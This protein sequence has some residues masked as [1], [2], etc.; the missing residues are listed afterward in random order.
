MPR[1]TPPPGNHQLRARLCLDVLDILHLGVFRVR[2]EAVL[3]AVRAAEDVVSCTLN[4][5]DSGKTKVP[6]VNRVAGEIPGLQTVREWQPAQVAECQ[7]E[8]ESIG[9]DVHRCQNGR[10]VV[11]RVKDVPEL[12]DVDKDHR[13]GHVPMGVVLVGEEGK[14]EDRPHDHSGAELAEGLEVEVVD[15]RVEGPSDEPVVED[16]AGVCGEQLAGEEGGGVAVD[17]HGDR[18][19]ERAGDE[20]EEVVPDEG[21]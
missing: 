5:Q 10:L 16:V 21:P 4:C 7:H 13:V 14:V 3:G 6:Q 1:D 9:G 15:A 12:E 17:G 8:P 18:E 2:T 20:L 19:E 11:E